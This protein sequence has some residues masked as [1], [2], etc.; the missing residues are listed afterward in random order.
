MIIAI[1]SKN[2]AKEKACYSAIKKLGQ[3]FPNKFKSESKFL[4]VSAPSSVSNMPLTLNEVLNGARNRAFFT[5][6]T[7]I[8]TTPVNFAI[9][10]EG[11]VF[12]TSEIEK[13]TNQAIL[14][15]WVYIYNGKI[16]FFGCS[17]G[18][19]LP[20][21]ISLPLFNDKKELAEVIDKASGKKDVHSNNGAFGILT[22]NLYTRSQA[23]ES[24]II[25]AFVPFFNTDYY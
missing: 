12:L 23:F 10:M 17:A 8:S 21:K 6:K 7:L 14:Q 15:N 4:S 19:P 11:G 25:N 3:T 18:I 20:E 1:G 24:A 13:N 16:G 22:E 2:K 9:G 5:Y